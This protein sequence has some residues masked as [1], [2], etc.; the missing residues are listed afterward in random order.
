MPGRN[1]SPTGLYIHIPFCHARCGYCDFVTFTGKEDKIDSYVDDLCKEISMMSSPA[2]TGGG[3]INDL[4][5]PRQGHSGVTVETIFFGGGTP[6]VLEIHQ[7]EK[8][9]KAAHDN[10]EIDPA[11]EIT[12]E[13]NPESI[14]PDKAAGWLGAGINRI[15][16]GL[17]AFDDVLLKSMGRLHTVEQFEAAYAAVRVAGFKNVS[18]DLIYGFPGQDLDSWQSTVRSAAALGPDHL[19]LYSLTVEEHT[20]FAS[21]GVTVDNDLQAQ[22]YEW[23]RGYLKGQGL[24]QYEIS[25]FARPGFDCRHNLIYWRQQDYVGLGAGAVGCMGNLRWTNQKTLA[26]YHNDIKA[27]RLPRLSIESLD[28]SA[29]KFENLMLGLRLREGFNWAQEENPEWVAHRASLHARGLLE[30]ITPG[31]WRIPDAA[32]PLTNQVLLP[33]L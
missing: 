3:S 31:R 13:A 18:F 5:G 6:S 28:S 21:S 10:F 23:A 32:V 19:S 29:R 1:P 7:I 14:S 17:Q 12:L 22:M 9:L 26:T 25:N 30:E 2:V 16:I 11:A 33:F 20:P 27:G 15:S 24:K 4:M 8:I